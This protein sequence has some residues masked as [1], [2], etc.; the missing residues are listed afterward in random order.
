MMMGI[1]KCKKAILSKVVRSARSNFLPSCVQLGVREGCLLFSWIKKFHRLPACRWL[2]RGFQVLR[3]CGSCEERL[4][5]FC[6]QVVNLKLALRL[7]LISSGVE[8]FVAN[9]EY[10]RVVLQQAV[11]DPE[12]NK[13]GKN[14]MVGG[15]CNYGC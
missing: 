15:N 2:W 13:K 4:P 5:W 6:H 7:L 3:A 9:F 14:K 12:E 10:L 8:F 11:V 1:T